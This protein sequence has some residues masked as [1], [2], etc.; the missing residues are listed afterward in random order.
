MPVKPWQHWTIAGTYSREAAM[1]CDGAGGYSF[2]AVKTKALSE[3]PQA[4]FDRTREHSDDEN[5]ILPNWMQSRINRDGDWKT[6]ASD[7]N[8]LETQIPFASAL[9]QG[10]CPDL[11]Q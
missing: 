2:Y 9:G 1:K 8:Y 6:D 5:V 3:E 7:W 11:I 4:F 10:E